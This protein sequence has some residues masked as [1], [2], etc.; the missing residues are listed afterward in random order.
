MFKKI[1][2]LIVLL[3]L[4]YDLYHII[5]INM[6]DTIK[7]KNINSI[8]NKSTTIDTNKVKNINSI[9]NKTNNYFNSKDFIFDN[10]SS[11]YSDSDS[12]NDISDSENDISDSEND[13]SDSEN[14]ISEN[15][16]SDSEN[17]I[18]ENDISENDNSDSENDNSDNKIK[19][20]NYYDVIKNNNDKIK[21]NIKNYE[22]TKNQQQY[23]QQQ[24]NQQQY[25]QQQYN[26]QQ[27]DQQQYNQ[28]QYNQQQYNQ[29][30]Y[31]QQQYNQQQYNQQLDQQQYNQQL[32]Q[33]QYNQQ[34][35]NQQ[36]YNQQQ[37]E[38][39]TMQH[40][41]EENI[42]IPPIHHPK[43]TNEN[44]NINEFGK[45]YDYKE[46]KYIHWEFYDPK[47]WTKIIYNYGE[48][49]PYYY[50]LKAKIPSLNDYQNWKSIIINLD[51]DPRSGELI[52]PCKDEETALSIA[53]LIVSNFKGDIKLEEIINKDLLGISILKCRKFEIVKNKLRDQII[54]NMIVK[55][56]SFNDLNKNIEV[57]ETNKNKKH[58]LN[59]NNNNYFYY[60]ENNNKHETDLNAYDGNEFSFI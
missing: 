46:N 10:N 16:I 27:L 33:Q 54:Q 31:N 25:N 7:V 57:V 21:N 42:L 24:Y 5:E 18:S 51:F 29:Q 49:Y 17:D 52:I 28:Q 56:Q 13:I 23:N 19:S 36:Q 48:E 58:I 1:I 53:N 15:D 8:N 37:L 11:N 30:Q 59:I 6:P 20:F 3:I 12:E 44:I 60:D 47:P 4:L 55:H 38:Q 50:Y 34:Q 41:N 45:P 39:D 2:F 40:I 14:D 9:N 22:N 26:Q 35:Y 43:I 32:N